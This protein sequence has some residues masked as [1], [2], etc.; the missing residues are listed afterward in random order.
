MYLR[1]PGGRQA[2]PIL[3][4]RHA[5]RLLFA[6]SVPCVSTGRRRGRAPRSCCGRKHVA[7]LVYLARSPRKSRT[8]EHLIGLLWSDP[9][10]RRQGPSLR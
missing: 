9:A 6:C 5:L 7:L 1:L 2:Y 4:G 8:R 10:T 3:G